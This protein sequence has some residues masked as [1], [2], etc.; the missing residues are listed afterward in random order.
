MPR[1]VLIKAET[2][3]IL[4]T[5]I[6]TLPKL[7]ELQA[8]VGGYIE[9]IP[10]FETYNGEKCVAFCNEEGKLKGFPPNHEAHRL[11]QKAVGRAISNDY[12]VGDIF[13]I[14]GDEKFLEA[15]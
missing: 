14:V 15:L 12:L 2:G 1:T 13:I 5:P 3:S 7:A 11:W 8:A 6:T 10:Y 4:E 9:V